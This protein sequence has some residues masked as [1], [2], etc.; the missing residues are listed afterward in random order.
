MY[1]VDT[2]ADQNDGK[3]LVKKHLLYTSAQRPHCQQYSLGNRS[4]FYRAISWEP[5]ALKVKSAHR[6]SSP[7]DAVIQS[8]SSRGSPLLYTGRT[9]AQ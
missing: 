2:G 7:I 6:G 1:S 5:T 3:L 8:E 4:S 9:S